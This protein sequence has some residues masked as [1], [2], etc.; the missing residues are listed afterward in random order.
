MR[1][2]CSRSAPALSTIAV[3]PL[4][5]NGRTID[6]SNALGAH[7]MT[8]SATPERL[9]MG[10]IAGALDNVARKSRCFPGSCNEIAASTN[11][12]KPRS[13]ASTTLRPIAPR[14]TTAMRISPSTI[15]AGVAIDSTFDHAFN[16]DAAAIHLVFQIDHRRA[17]EMPSQ[18]IAKHTA[19]SK[20]AFQ[21]RIHV[22]HRIELHR[23]RL[24]PVAGERTHAAFHFVQ[25]P[26][27]LFQHAGRAGVAE[28]DDII[29]VVRLAF[30][31]LAAAGDHERRRPI[32]R[33]SRERKSVKARLGW[34]IELRTDV[35]A[36]HRIDAVLHHAPLDQRLD[37]DLV[38]GLESVFGERRRGTQLAGGK[39]RQRPARFLDDFSDLLKTLLQ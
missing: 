23:R 27:G 3:F 6:F 11:P 18:T 25:Y 32:W 9:S 16:M 4:L 20:L 22:L 1:S 19:F 37:I 7:S 29:A 5:T 34:R 8:T 13:S 14:P 30:H 12:S 26:L 24:A 21:Q 17:V 39:G 15:I 2:L 28:P 31:G 36:S 38:E 10:R 35:A 33:D